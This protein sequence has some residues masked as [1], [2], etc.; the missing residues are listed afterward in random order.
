[1]DII[2]IIQGDL[3]LL[4]SQLTNSQNLTVTYNHRQTSN[5]TD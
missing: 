5:D 4:I 2:L 1:M 3:Y